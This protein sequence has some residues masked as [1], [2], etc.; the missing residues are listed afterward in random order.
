MDW[1]IADWQIADWQLA[2]NYRSPAFMGGQPGIGPALAETAL[3]NDLVNPGYGR[4]CSAPICLD[5]HASISNLL[6]AAGEIERL[7]Y[8]TRNNANATSSP[9]GSA[10]A[11]H[12]VRATTTREAYRMI[13]VPLLLLCGLLSVFMAA[14]IPF[15]LLVHG[16]RTNSVKTWR[17]VNTLQLV[18]DTVT[19]LHDEYIVDQMEIAGPD[20][21]GKLARTAKVKYEVLGGKEVALKL[22]DE[23]NK[24]RNILGSGEDTEVEPG[25]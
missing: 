4:N 10:A 13:Y 17:E 21:S 18:A 3:P 14:L 9:G 5:Y 11:T 16:R 2:L 19:G 24:G 15:G 25:Q 22:A 6:Y 7:A 12:D 8:E 23:P 20:G 1:L